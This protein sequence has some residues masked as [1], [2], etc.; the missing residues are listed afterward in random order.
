MVKLFV[1]IFS[2]ALA[3][4]DFDH[5][6]TLNP[7]N[8]MI[9]PLHSKV[10]ECMTKLLTAYV[11]KLCPLPAI[12]SSWASWSYNELFAEQQLKLDAVKPLIDIAQRKKRK[13]VPFLYYG[14]DL[15]NVEWVFHETEYN[16]A[17]GSLG[18]YA[19]QSLSW[20]RSNFHT[21]ELTEIHRQS[22]NDDG[23]L[24]LLNAMRE[25]QKPLEPLDSSAIK[26]IKTPIKEN[27]DGI[28]AT[29]LHSKNADVKEINMVEL[30]KLDAEPMSFKANDSVVFGGYYKQKLVKKYSLE[31][32][33]HLPQIW[34][35]IEGITYPP[36]YHLAKSELDSLRKKHAA[37]IKDRKYS[38]LAEIDTQIDQYQKEVLQ[39]KI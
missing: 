21:I 38:E 32:L 7:Q 14:D 34:S 10:N 4:N 28:K 9:Q 15:L 3:L 37:L 20:Q 8:D 22:D 18:V 19:F 13:F 23:L 27:P 35:C 17:V 33:S 29:Q 25:G 1:S 16:N 31:Q 39:I 30:R 11:K 26:A 6:L 2:L 36:R 12:P 24:K 5:A